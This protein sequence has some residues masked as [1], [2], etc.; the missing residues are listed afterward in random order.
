M[1]VSWYDLILKVST[2]SPCFHLL[3]HYRIFQYPIPDSA[4]RLGPQ[5]VADLEKQLTTLGAQRL[6]TF[7]V[8]SDPYFPHPNI[9]GE[10]LRQLNERVLIRTCS[11]LR[12]VK[13]RKFM[14]FHR[15][16]DEQLCCY[17]GRKHYQLRCR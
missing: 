2:F 17:Y 9:P 5:I 4:G 3:L 8:D 12:P 1:G 7:T 15:I 16:S 10:I 11:T 14:S 6:G 13:Y